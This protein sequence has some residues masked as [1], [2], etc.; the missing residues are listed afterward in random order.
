MKRTYIIPIAL[1]LL[2]V[3][4]KKYTDYSGVTFTEVEPRDWE[5]PEM[6]NQ[7]REEP[8]ATFISYPDADEA[9]TFTKIGR[10][11]V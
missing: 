8:R 1:V 10:A 5:N 9:L 3:S 11:H 7:N 2:L 6:F 4:C